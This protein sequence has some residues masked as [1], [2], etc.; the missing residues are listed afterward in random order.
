M[1]PDPVAQGEPSRS[2]EVERKFDVD[3]GTPVP[4]WESVPGVARVTDGEP[5]HLDALYLD[6]AEAVL[7]RAG[8]ALRRRTGGP[9]AGW[10]IKGPLVDGGRTELGWPLGETDEVPEAVAAEVARWTTDPLTPL[11]RIVNDRTA[12]ALLDAEGGVLAEFV[13]DHVRTTDLRAGTEREWHEWEVEL[14]PAA[15]AAHETREVFFAAVEEAAIAAGARQASSASK[16][17]RA[18]GH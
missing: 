11:A 7:A 17:A 5:R 16:L 4:S 2:I 9:D 13:D 10:H 12:Y 6:T 18:L 15:P 8:V 14:G 1:T 3:A